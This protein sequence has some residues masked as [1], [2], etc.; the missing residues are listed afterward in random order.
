MVVSDNGSVFTSKEFTDFMTYN[1]ITCVKS[2][3]YHPSTNG[4]A[5]CAVQTFR[6]GVKKL[7]EGTLKSVISFFVSLLVDTSNNNW[8]ISS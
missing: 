5:E 4:L 1:G 6:A 2:S 3:P 7:T 8:T